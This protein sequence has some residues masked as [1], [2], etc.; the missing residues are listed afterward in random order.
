MTYLEI[1]RKYWGYEGFRGIQSQ[2]IG[3]IGSGRDTLGLMPTGGGKSITFQVPAMSMEG[4]CLVITPLIALMKDQ[5]RN[6]RDRGIR[7]C[8]IYSGMKHD[9]VVE[10][11]EDCIFGGCK[12]LYVS[13]ERISSELFQAKLRHMKVSMITVDEAH[14]ISQWGY[15]FRPSYLKIAEIRGILPGI[16]VLALTATATPKVADDIQDCLGFRERNLFR[17]SFNRE[18]L[19]YIVRNTDNKMQELTLILGKVPGS[20][21][22][23]VRNR[24]ETKEISDTLKKA[25]IT[26]SFYHAG[27]DTAVKDSRQKDW[28]DGT[29]R[30]IVATNAFGMGIDKPD[31][32]L[33]I[34]MDLPDSPEAYFQEAGRAGRDGDTAYAV[35]LFSPGDKRKLTKRISD[36]FPEKDF[37]RKVYEK[38]SYYHVMAVGDGT[39]CT[40]DFSLSEFCSSYSLPLIQT[41][42]ALRILTRMGYIEYTE[43]ADFS[44]R[45]QFTTTREE[46]YGIRQADDT[47]EKVISTIL[48]TYSGVFTEQCFIDERMIAGRAGTDAHTLYC[49]LTD[50]DRRGIVRYVPS[51]RTPQ[52]I[53]KRARVESSMLKFTPEVYELRREEYAERIKSMTEYAT[54]ENGCRSEML[55]RYF[56]ERD[57]RPCQRCDLCRARHE[58]GFTRGL[59]ENIRKDILDKLGD[60]PESPELIFTLP[61]SRTQIEAVLE[62]LLSEEE[63]TMEDGRLT[64][65]NLGNE[66]N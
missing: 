39:G 43:E 27:L 44:A 56:G 65:N 3:S 17:M 58:S 45:L 11:L 61:Y 30:V 8:A 36:S 19:W 40:F 41:D 38:L 31:V 42:S 60:W 34:H 57:V 24:R 47:T 29:T 51:R 55:L 22:V 46:L 52:I 32:R 14:C 48:R 54:R 50:L 16:P 9:E 13:P 12:F 10:A 49:I 15:D 37:I 5:V 25:G 23:Y 18:N 33:V 35:L 63:L 53:W 6:L 59:Y 20:A 7:A 28:T 1:L 62:H 66:K 21:I 64:I 26:S 2:I 4:V